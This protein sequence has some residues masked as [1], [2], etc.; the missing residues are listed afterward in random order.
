M[1]KDTY[2]TRGM[3]RAANRE[4]KTLIKKAMKAYAP[5]LTAGFIVAIAA[6]F[7]VEFILKGGLILQAAGAAIGC[8]LGCAIGFR[9]KNRG[10]LKGLFVA[11]RV[12]DILSGS[13]ALLAGI[14]GMAASLTQHK[15]LGLACSMFFVAGGYV[16]LRVGMRTK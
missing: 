15:W 10:V 1:N 6:A 11:G 7:T 14:G 4:E 12:I 16:L 9:I 3:R 13:I 8:L 5:I 2:Q